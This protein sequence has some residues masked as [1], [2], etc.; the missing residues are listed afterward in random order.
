MVAGE[1]YVG[2][3]ETPRFVDEAQARLFLSKE[4][5]ARKSLYDDMLAE[6]VLNMAHEEIAT[7]KRECATIQRNRDNQHLIPLVME[8]H[9]NV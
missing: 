3:S 8:N 7:F 9:L 1:W 6:A 5:L 4:L 2:K